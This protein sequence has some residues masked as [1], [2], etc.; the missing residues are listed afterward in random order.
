MR[1]YARAHGI[2]VGKPISEQDLRELTSAWLNDR[3]SGLRAILTDLEAAAWHVEIIGSQF[4][5]MFESINPAT[6]KPRGRLD[7]YDELGWPIWVKNE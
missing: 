2:T 5:E 7:H 6:G 1:S 4:Q 3:K